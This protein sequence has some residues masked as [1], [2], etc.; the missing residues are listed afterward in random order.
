M[1]DALWYFARGSG[2]VSL[3][4]LTVVVALGIGARSGRPAFGLPRFAVSL[5]SAAIA[6]ALGE[7]RGAGRDRVPVE[8]RAAA[9]AFVA[10]EESAAVAAVAGRR[11]VPADKRIRITDAGALVQNVETLAHI[12]LIARHGAGWFRPRAR[13]RSPARSSPP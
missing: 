6:A 10:G 13:R 8:I 2:L 12:A 4:L 3:V 7:R 5:P 1:T 9:D 11:A